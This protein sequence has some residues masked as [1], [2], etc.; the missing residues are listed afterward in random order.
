MSGWRLERLNRKL[1]REVVVGQ[2]AAFSGTAGQL[3]QRM[4]TG[5]QARF[6]AVNAQGG[7]ERSA[8]DVSTVTSSGTAL[9]TVATTPKRTLTLR[10]MMG[11]SQALA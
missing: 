2:F 9:S 4:R 6:K 5:I 8:A 3:G 11:S 10:F 7:S 1:Q